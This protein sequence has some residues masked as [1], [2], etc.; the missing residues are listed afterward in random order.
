[1]KKGNIALMATTLAV[2]TAITNVSEA[3]NSNTRWHVGVDVGLAQYKQERKKPV[4]PTYKEIQKLLDEYK[5]NNLDKI[6]G[7]QNLLTKVL[8]DGDGHGGSFN[9]ELRMAHVD[10]QAM[11]D[12]VNSINGAANN[13]AVRGI[14]VATINRA[15][16]QLR[17]WGVTL[18]GANADAIIQTNMN[19]LHN[20]NGNLNNVKNQVLGYF[21]ALTDQQKAAALTTEDQGVK[22]VRPNVLLWLQNL[23]YVNEH[24]SG[25]EITNIKNAITAKMNELE[26]TEDDT[27]KDVTLLQRIQQFMSAQKYE[28]ENF[29]ENNPELKWAM[30]DNDLQTWMTTNWYR[31]NINGTTYGTKQEEFDNRF[32]AIKKSISDT[33]AKMILPTEK[34]SSGRITSPAIEANFGVTRQ[35]GKGILGAEIFVGVHTKDF[36][37]K[38]SKD[39]YPY[40]QSRMPVYGAGIV[41]AGFM[42]GDRAEVYALGGARFNKLSPIVGAGVRLYSDTK[43][44]FFKAEFQQTL[45]KKYPKGHTIKLGFGW[46]I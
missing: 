23:A 21:N 14:V 2:S 11:N 27:I 28:Y 5:A 35:F 7:I 37:K 36:K 4:L 12:F 16:E 40:T 31:H 3:C 19:L 38:K 43:S 46:T 22:R 39:L 10:D 17:K 30:T 26:Q 45:G 44:Y 33:E 32:A 42:L 34:T 41:R 15:N 9:T 20:D 8:I 24:K 18:L 29:F 6:V 1:M 13:A 25:A